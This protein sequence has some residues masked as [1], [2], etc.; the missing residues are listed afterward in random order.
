MFAII[1]A[2]VWALFI[3]Y[4][5]ICLED[6]VDNLKEQIRIA[7]FVANHASDRLTNHIVATN[8]DVYRLGVA[9]GFKP[10]FGLENGKHVVMSW[11]KDEPVDEDHS[12]ILGAF[13]A[14]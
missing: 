6:E 12:G 10:I 13:P 7:R 4:R 8:E 3:G 9:L 1:C 14:D 2:I 11:A 5:I